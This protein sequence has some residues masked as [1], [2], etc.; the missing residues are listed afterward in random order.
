MPNRNNRRAPH[1]RKV[2]GMTSGGPLH[3]HDAKIEPL[4]AIHRHAADFWMARASV[5]VIAALQLAT[6]NNLAIGPQWLAPALEIALLIPL[7]IGTAWTQSMARDATTDQHWAVV[8][9]ARRLIRAAALVLTALISLMNIVAVCDL[10]RLMLSGHAHRTGATLLLDAM[11]LWITNVMVFALW[12]WSIDRGGPASR[13]VTKCG[14]TDFLFPQLRLGP[15]ECPPNWSPGYLDYLYV[16]FT[17]AT[18][19][20]PTDTLPLTAY[21]K[22]LMMFESAVSLLT[23]ALIVGRAISIMM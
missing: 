9:R 5:G 10:V 21:A 17:N 12:F 13:G 14:P 2:R 23:I 8:A 6:I 18:A 11:N 4:M 7:S 15:P 16:A 22:L 3:A 19:F 1:P 20:S